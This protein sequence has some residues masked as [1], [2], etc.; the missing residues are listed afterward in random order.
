MDRRST[1]LPLLAMLQFQP[2]QQSISANCLHPLRCRTE[3]ICPRW[4][5]IAVCSPCTGSLNIL[6]GS[7]GRSHIPRRSVQYSR[8]KQAVSYEGNCTEKNAWRGNPW[9]HNFD[10]P[11]GMLEREHTS[12]KN[13]SVSRQKQS[14][15]IQSCQRKLTRKVSKTRANVNGQPPTNSTTQKA[16]LGRKVAQWLVESSGTL[17]KTRMTGRSVAPSVQRRV[18]V[19]A[20]GRGAKRWRLPNAVN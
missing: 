19:S 17:K 9:H 1:L 20:A 16:L 2:L 8:M 14:G 5:N 6:T 11:M 13:G 15:N 10:N 3:S 4:Q 7:N 12:M 18:R